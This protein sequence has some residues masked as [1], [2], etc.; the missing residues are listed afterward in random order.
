MALSPET[1]ERIAVLRQKS[2]ENT[3]TQEEMREAI[4]LMRNERLTAHATSATSKAR[5]STAAAKKGPINSDDL[6]S[7]L[8]GL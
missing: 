1:I 5:K 8:D 2:R 6:L 4:N 7:E 3:L